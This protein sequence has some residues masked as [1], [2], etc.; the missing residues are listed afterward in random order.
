[1][2]YHGRRPLA[3][4]VLRRRI[5]DPQSAKLE[6][7]KEGC[8]QPLPTADDALRMQDFLLDEAGFDY[9]HVLTNEKATA[10]RIRELMDDI[11]PDLI[12]EN[13][14]FFHWSG[15]GDT[16]DRTPSFSTI[17]GNFL[18]ARSWSFDLVHR[19]RQ[20]DQRCLETS[21]QNQ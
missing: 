18:E 16:R 8:Y 21:M 13:D 4:D 10:E 3:R 9:V 20:S 5:T 14:R 19:S 7:M 11:F 6:T 15:H 12:T 17:V 1:M 2:S